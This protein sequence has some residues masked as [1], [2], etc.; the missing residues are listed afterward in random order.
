[1][2]VDFGL[3]VKDARITV[4]ADNTV[5]PILAVDEKFVGRVSHAGAAGC[6][7]EHGLSLL[8]Q[9]KAE[10]GEHTILLDTCGPKATVLN[11]MRELNINPSSIEAVVTS[12]GHYDHFG[13]LI[14]V[15]EKLSPGSKVI[16]HPEVF[17]VKYALRGELSGKNLS[18]SREEMEKLVRNGRAARLPSL[19]REQVERVAQVKRLEIVESSGPVNL[20]SGVWASGEIPVRYP[21]ELSSGLYVERGNKMLFDAFR[22]EKSVYIKVEGKGVIVLTGCCHRGVANTTW[23]AQRLSGSKVYAVIG[24]L[25][26]GNASQNRIAKVI[27]TLK[28]V[29]P[30]IISP[31]HCSGVKFTS[32]LL[33]DMP[34]ITV[35]SVVGTTF[36]L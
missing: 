8:M 26:M 30:D 35:V 25:H 20:A 21:D 6:L 16:L 36:T 23:D 24:G 3:G 29:S 2:K 5:N 19:S 31:L 1:M 32:R 28:D 22:D 34:E 4:L 10:D 15:M 13:S 7:G 27:K 12:H 33:H 9:V 17:G 14:K 18:V 11:N